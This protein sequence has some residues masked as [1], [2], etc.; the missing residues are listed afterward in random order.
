MSFGQPEKK[1]VLGLYE[2]VAGCNFRD[3]FLS[4]QRPPR[5]KERLTIWASPV[6]AAN[7]VEG[8]EAHYV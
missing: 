2:V 8:A 7:M 3:F 1:G 6:G 4:A 5:T